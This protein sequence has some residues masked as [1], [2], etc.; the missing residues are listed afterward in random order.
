MGSTLTVRIDDD[1]ADWLEVTA[2]ER[3]VSKGRLVRDQI[4]KARTAASE[5]GFM[6]LAGVIAG[7][8]NLSGRKGFSKR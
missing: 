6:R 2:R 7:P 1:L 3:G 4:E 8:K 5:P